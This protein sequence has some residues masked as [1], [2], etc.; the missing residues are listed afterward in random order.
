MAGRRI[1]AAGILVATAA[2]SSLRP[3]RQPVR[4]IAE[5]SPPV[6]TVAYVFNGVGFTREMANPRVV[7]DSVYGT[8]TEG[9][10]PAAVPV[11]DIHAVAS[12][13]RDPTRTAFL[14]AG[15]TVAAGIMTYA[16]F[17]KSNGQSDWACDYNTSALS[18]SGAPRC[19]P[20]Q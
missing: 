8:W 3:V 17:Q 11:S 1:T 6:V 18:G 9:N 10:R 7:G 4:Y 13:R 20:A 14:V 5:T 19:G 2:C 16:L 15:V 12:L